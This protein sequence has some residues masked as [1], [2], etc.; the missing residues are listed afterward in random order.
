[1]GFFLRDVHF[2]PINPIQSSIDGIGW[3][4]LGGLHIDNNI[5]NFPI[6]KWHI[7][8]QIEDFFNPYI[9]RESK[10]YTYINI[11]NIYSQYF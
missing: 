2:N 11:Y 5:E 6:R 8:M 1:M 3:I 7:G 9:I 4:G 10:L